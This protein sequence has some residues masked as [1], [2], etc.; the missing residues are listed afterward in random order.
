[1]AFDGLSVALL[2]ISG[3]D[4]LNEQVYKSRHFSALPTESADEPCF[5]PSLAIR[6]TAPFPLR[7]FFGAPPP[8]G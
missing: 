8:L 5:S 3:D 4:F 2:T 1:M 6:R 7:S